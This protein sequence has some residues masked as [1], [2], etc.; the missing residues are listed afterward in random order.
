VY[1]TDS[2]GTTNTVTGER[3]DGKGYDY[4]HFTG[5]NP[6]YDEQMTAV[7]SRTLWEAHMRGR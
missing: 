1:H 5:E 2:W 4:V 7:D 6:K 3:W